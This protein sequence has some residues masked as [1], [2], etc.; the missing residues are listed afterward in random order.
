DDD[1][2]PRFLVRHLAEVA[3]AIER[4]V[5]VRGYMHWSL[6]DSFEWAEGYAPRFGLVE[7]D[8]VTQ[9]RS[10]RPSAELYAR[11]A[12]ARRIDADGAA[13]VDAPRGTSTEGS[14][15]PA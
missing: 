13:F 5:D 1:Q 11:I 3:R 9:E 7:V 6:L 15:A 8:H 14:A 10:P 12:R 4:G 2:R